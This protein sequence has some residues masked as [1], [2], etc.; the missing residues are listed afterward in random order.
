MVHWKKT[1]AIA[2]VLVEVAIAASQRGP[3]DPGPRPGPPAA[4]AVATAATAADGLTGFYPTLNATEQAAY[5][6]GIAQFVQLEGVPDQPPGSGK[7]R[8]GAG[9]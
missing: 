1:A 4:G 9:V 8:T 5:A 7:W 6:N 3:H 2:T